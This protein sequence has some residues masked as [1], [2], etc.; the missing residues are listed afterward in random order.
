[1][2]IQQLIEDIK[3]EGLQVFGPEKL[4]SYVYFTDGTRIGYAQNA[5]VDGISFS[6][7]H[8]P[9]RECGTGFKVDSLQGALAHSPSWAT[10]GDR[11]AVRKFK[12]FAEFTS[13]HW[14]P[15]VQY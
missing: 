13:K 6:T 15:L 8:K 4:T 1:M 12:D 3:L 5:R 10:G 14:Q 11:S 7:V 9:C 2:S